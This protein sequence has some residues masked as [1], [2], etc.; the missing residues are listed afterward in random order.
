LGI[1]DKQCWDFGM[2]EAEAEENAVI[3]SPLK[4]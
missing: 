3:G 4:E 2:V 1:G